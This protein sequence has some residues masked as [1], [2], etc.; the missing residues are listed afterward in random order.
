[1]KN[2]KF[3]MKKFLCRLPA[4]LVIPLMIAVLAGCYPDESASINDLDIVITNYD[5]GYNF[6]GI[7][8]YLM[9]D[10]V[11]AITDPANPENNFEYKHTYDNMIL[12]ELASQFG[13]LGYN[14]VYDTLAVKP[15][16]TVKVSAVSTTYIGPEYLWAPQYNYQVG[17]IIV[18]MI[19][20]KSNQ[21][22]QTDS[23]SVVWMGA[24]NGL[25][26]GSNIENRIRSGIGQMF[27]QSPYL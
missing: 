27:I 9:P 5:T 3:T 17:T 7:Q 11:I 26:E 4:I 16:V 12:S 10:T 8:S 19:D 2:E 25:V 20:M 6:S 15:D 22:L 13:T 14:R 1:M 24:I 21:A 23:V 18:T